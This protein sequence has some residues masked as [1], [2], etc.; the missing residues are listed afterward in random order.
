MKKRWWRGVA[1]GVVGL[2][3]LWA[4]MPRPPLREG[5]GFSQAVMDRQGRLLRLTLSPDE[6][7]RLWVPLA[8][9]PPALVEATLLHEDQHFRQ[10]L[11]VNPV[12]VGRAIWRTWILR[13]R[14]VGG[15]T[16][17]MQLARI[18]YGIDSRTPRGKV[19]QM[20]RALQL[21]CTWSKD[22]ILEAY[23][24]LAPYGRNVEGV[25]A[26]SLVYF[27]KGVE[28]LSLAESL[29]LS[30]IPQS[31][32][33]RDPT[34]DEGALTAARLRLFDR[35]LETHPGDSERRTALSAPLSVRAPGELPFLAP[36]FVQATL[37]TLPVGSGVMTTLDLSLQRQLERHVRQYI[38]RRKA[39]GI[40]NAAAMLVDW[41]TLEVRAAVGSGDFFDK[42]IEGQVNGT[43]AKRSPGSA[44]KPFIYGLAFDQG[45]I[46][47]RTMLKDTPTGFAGYGPENFDGSFAGPLPAEEALT[48]SRNVPAVALASRL[49]APS[50]YGFLRQA[51]ITGL[52]SEEFYGLSLALGSAEVTM[53]ELVEL[54]AM[55][56]N[57]GVLRPLRLEADSP[58]PEGVR[59]L[60]AE[61][62][63]LVLEALKGAK[64]PAQTYQSEWARDAVPVAWKT[65]TSM[66]YRDAWSVGVA[67]PYVI[68]VWV[69]N[70]NGRPNP[71]F[72][73]QW[74]AAP[75]LFEMVDS[76]RA[77]DPDMHRVRWTPPAGV[78]RVSVCALSGGI[79]GPHCQRQVSTWFIPGTSPIQACDVHREIW[80]DSRTGKRACGPGPSA[81]AEVYEFWSSDLLRL[82]QRAGIPRRV[83][84][85]ESESCGMAH[86]SAEGV[87]PQIT[88]PEQGVDYDVR[89]SATAPQTVPLAAVTDADVRQVFWFVDE[90]LVGTAPRGEP[91]H[92]VAKPGTYVVRAV[93]D[94][95]RSDARAL[96]VRLVP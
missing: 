74:A 43:E 47:P 26:A 17:T 36:H 86:A 56:A 82:F 75:L 91:L 37:R 78:S 28:K 19:W 44:L 61:A 46:H 84:P 42:D 11:G 94:R 33:R 92:W 25:G 22:D 80:V 31:P 96:R 4:V 34:R 90:Q 32:A 8:S 54:Y 89:A 72:V 29:T 2:A 76:L 35:W 24:N 50:L 59:M 79:P 20:V 1:G 65:G 15:S 51:G 5:L 57:G 64:R 27:G 68:A 70:F 40:R 67:G 63:F 93:D 39:V 21:E 41:R 9:I 71:A 77:K 52:R 66:G 10:H 60:S 38:E 13:G 95:G 62:S 12:A 73:G 88:T 58:R 30:V 81:R 3:V 18:R 23:L 45:L 55:L 48:R 14:R 85:P 7:Y 69:G 87:A 53:T 83:P 6:K 49:R 16:L